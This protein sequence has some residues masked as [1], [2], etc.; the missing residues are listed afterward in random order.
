MSLSGSRG[1][2]VNAG[3]ITALLI[4]L[5]LPAVG[6]F[7][8]APAQTGASADP[9]TTW[10]DFLGGSDSAQYSALTQINKSN[11]SSLEQAWFFPAGNNNPEFGFN[12][13]VVDHLM[14]VLGKKDAV[15]AVDVNTHQP[16]WVHETNTDLIIGRG[17]NYWSS[18][19]GSDRRIIYNADNCI[20]EL[21]ARTGSEIKTFGDQGCVDLRQGLGRDPNSINLIQSFSPGRVFKNLIIV[22]SATGEEYGSPPGDIRA[23]DVLTGRQAWSF[24]TVPRPGDPGYATWPPDAWKYVGGTNNWGT[25]TLDSK[26]GIVYVPTGAPTYDFYGAGR[27]GANLYADCL[28]AL[29][30]STGRLIWYYQFVHHDLWDYD[31]AT[32]PSLMT[33]HHNGKVI[34]AVAEATKQGFLFVFD[35]V[36]GKPLWPI[37]ERPVP[38]TDVP[39]EE[40]WSSQP[41]PTMPPPFAR[42]KFTADDIDPYIADPQ[43]RSRLHETIQSARNQGLFTPPGMRDTVEMPGN[44]GGANWGGAAVDLSTGTLYVQSK[45]A[46]TLLRLESKP[47]SLNPSDFATP[48]EEGGVVYA[49]NCKTCHGE[50]L[51]GH[52]PAVP[53]LKNAMA[54]LGA[55]HIRQ[56]LKVG[57][58]PMPSFASLPASEEEALLT[59]LANPGA[60]QLSKQSLAWATSGNGVKTPGSER[61]WSGY[62][63]LFS[64]DALP[65][66]SPPWTT[67]TA[68]NLDEGKIRWQIPLGEMSQLAAKGIRN[69]GGGMR[70][71]VVVTAGGLIFAG[72]QGDRKLWAYDKDTGAVLWEKELPAVPNGVPAVFEVAGREYVVICAK[73]EELHSSSAGASPAAV[74]S[75]NVT[76]GYYAFALPSRNHP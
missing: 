41:F 64:T 29:D 33:V 40:S 18:N 10:S 36:S 57:A 52:P 17:F 8:I 71:G 73:E 44:A 45:D 60:V 12:P 25:M 51:G 39:G 65:D 6:S 72:T 74:S 9:H 62:G 70:G 43:E 32:G 21:D 76:Q 69:T 67:L 11:V 4:A 55:A 31:A 2:C 22:G 19:D 20:R 15:T 75:K 53:S 34:D 28:L 59:Y 35:R 3:R 24:H 48:A 16:A 66:I 13:I 61:Y 5:A 68:Y 30:A 37:E 27:K 63:Y 26:R 42:Q 50:D 23:Y 46:P 14:Y 58:P 56:I 1:L 38:Q 54:Q 7:Q 47:P 49:L